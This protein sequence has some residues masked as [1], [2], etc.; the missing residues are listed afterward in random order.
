MIQQQRQQQCEA[1][2]KANRADESEESETPQIK[3]ARLEGPAS[4]ADESGKS[5][6]LRAR[7]ARFET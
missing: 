5:E 6:R 3:G 1:Q 4:R 7:D 2:P